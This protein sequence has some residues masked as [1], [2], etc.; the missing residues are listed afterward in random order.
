[1][2]PEQFFQDFWTLGAKAMGKCLVFDSSHDPKVCIK[3][4]PSHAMLQGGPT[5]VLSYIAT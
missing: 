2:F 4:C 5:S 1:M 3:M